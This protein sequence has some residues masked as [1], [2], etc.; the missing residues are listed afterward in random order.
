MKKH[1]FHKAASLEMVRYTNSGTAREMST[2]NLNSG[3]PYQR[4]VKPSDV[5]ALIRRWDPAYLSPIEVS[6]RDGSYNVIN[7]QHRIE[8]MRKMNGGA[9]V[10]APCLIYTGLSY[11]QEAAM[12]YLLDKSVGR[13]KL[14]SAIKALLES[15]TD[16]TIIDIKQRIER[17]G[18]T[19]ALDK[20]TGVTYEIKPV[21]AIINAYHLLGAPAFSRMLGLMAGAW[22]GTQTSLA[23]DM[24]SGMAL[25]L[26]TYEKELDDYEVIRR[27][28]AIDP[29]VIIQMARVD[30]PPLRYARLIRAKYN[31]WPSGE[32]L[33]YRFNK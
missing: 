1:N 19:W 23:G 31:E 29:A 20:P 13:L 21:R 24:I 17:A 16:P 8:A 25:F 28:A 26:K 18:F 3:Q 30:T 14:S 12:Y 15:G 11:E 9:D 22:H 10:I 2:A 32:K 33:P 7:G 27:L 6:F 5:N 4:P